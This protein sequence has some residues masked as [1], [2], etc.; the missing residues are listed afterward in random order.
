M[1]FRSNLEAVHGI[2]C[3]HTVLDLPGEAVTYSSARIVGSIV[4]KGLFFMEK[5]GPDL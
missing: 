3:V 2:G 5:D 4:S 1:N